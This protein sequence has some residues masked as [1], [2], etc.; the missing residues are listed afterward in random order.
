MAAR[1]HVTPRHLSRLFAEHAGISPLNYLQ[2]IRLERAEQALARGASPSDAALAAGFSSDQQL[3]RTRR[4]RT[5]ASDA[6][7]H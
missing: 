2:T 3:R 4:A 5:G 7:R 6:P 1:A